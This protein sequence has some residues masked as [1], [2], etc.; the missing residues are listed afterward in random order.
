MAVRRLMAVL[1]TCLVA[2]LALPAAEET[3]AEF[4]RRITSEL[5]ARDAAAAGLFEQANAARDRGDRAAAIALYEQVRAK[6]PAFTHA[7][8]RLCGELLDA[9]RVADGK[10]L[11]REAATADPSA[12]NQAAFAQSLVWSTGDPPPPEADKQLAGKICASLIPQ[13]SNDVEVQ[14]ICTSV[15]FATNSLAPAIAGAT[16]LERLAPAE[17]SSLLFS[18][19]AHAVQGEFLRADLDLWRARQRGIPENDYSRLRSSFHDAWPIWLTAAVWS[20]FGVIGWLILAAALLVAGIVL[21]RATLAESERIASTPSQADGETAGRTPWL[22]RIYAVVIGL[23]GMSY[24]V[25]LPLVMVVV[26]LVG[27]GVLYGMLRVGHIPLNW[28]AMLLL[29]VLATCWSILKS[30]VIV[31][32]DKDPGIKADLAD[33]P[34]LDAVLKDVAAAI[35][36][37]PIDSVYLMP[38]TEFAVM[39]RG[40]MVER[41]QGRAERCLLLGVGVL[42]GFEVRPFR[43]VLAHEYGHFVNRDTAGGKISLAVRRSILRMAESL[44]RAGAARAL[45]PAWLFLVAF[46]NLFQRISQGAS[47][48]Q[49]VM[50]D[51]WAVGAYGAQAFCDGL[52]HV[53]ERSVRFDARIG[54]SLGEIRSHDVKPSNL[55]AFVPAQQPDETEV[56]AAVEQALG[57]PSSPYDSHPSPAQR[58]EWASRLGGPGLVAAADA[59]DAW[60]LLANRAAVETSMTEFVFSNA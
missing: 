23:A 15:A 54:A 32:R 48:L 38:G 30:L 29:L 55:Y 49:E 7:T 53:I 46:G 13:A 27:G 58:F 16:N 6:Q 45:N 51:R 35:G 60:G 12:L 26:L 59:D 33:H 50:A 44:A 10:A 57:R 24:Y 1:V 34:R 14:R 9:G 31:S 22:R 8:R 28:F 18:A 11:C 5:R 20:T 43:A 41:L 36:T 3:L 56:A 52:R 4:D 19:I 39:E 17:P 21:S 2:G 37:R 25:S 40:R 42:E 47:R